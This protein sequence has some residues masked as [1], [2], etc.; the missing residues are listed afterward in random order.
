MTS[1]DPT[2][3]QQPATTAQEPAATA[4]EAAPRPTGSRPPARVAVVTGRPQSRA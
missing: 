4:P 3:A 2:P 1:Q